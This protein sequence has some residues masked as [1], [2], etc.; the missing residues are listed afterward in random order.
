MTNPSTFLPETE[1]AVPI[2]HGPGE[3]TKVGVLTSHTLFKVLP[4]QTGGAYAILEQDIPSGIGPPLHV[5]KH[6]TEIFYVLEGDFEIRIGGDVVQAPAGA[7]AVCPRE[8]PHTFRNVGPSSGKLLLT[9]IPGHFGNYFREV[10]EIAN[11]DAAAIKALCAKYEV[12]IL[13]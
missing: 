7:M 6:E 1:T 8:I 13:E 4:E 9:V 11:H 2:V 12:D 5:H 10:N 3:G